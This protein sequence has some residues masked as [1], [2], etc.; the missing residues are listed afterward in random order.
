MLNSAEII[1]MK[2]LEQ[3]QVEIL[4]R[5]EAELQKAKLECT[6][7]QQLP[8]DPYMIHV[9]PLYGSI[10]SVKYKVKT[11]EEAAYIF[12][13][14]TDKSPTYST[15]SGSAKSMRSEWDEKADDIM[16]CLFTVD[17]Q[18]HSQEVSFFVDI[19][20][21]KIRVDIEF[22]QGTFGRF[23]KVNPNKRIYWH[24]EFKPESG[25]TGLLRVANY[26][27]VASYGDMSSP[28]MIY[29]GFESFE[30]YDA[31]GINRPE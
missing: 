30:F 4:S 17:I 3:R 24:W 19:M 27:R 25:L 1:A 14:F 9:Y 26:A 20:P 29:A 11:K 28:H 31:V 5:A 15:K 8:I 10:G 6:I 2:I 21:G 12:E 18:L 22:P 13:S 23:Y 16:Q 7:L